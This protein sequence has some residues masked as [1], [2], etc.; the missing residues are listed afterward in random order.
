MS[1]RLHTC[2]SRGPWLAREPFGPS[3][4]EIVIENLDSQEF[5]I[6]LQDSFR[7][8]F[9]VSP[10]EP[11]EH[12]FVEREKASVE[13]RC[14]SGARDE[15]LYRAAIEYI[16]FAGAGEARENNFPGVAGAFA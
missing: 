7:F 12:F 4:H 9:R 10:D 5:W 8:D 3:S 14:A 1:H 11:L 13:Y 16:C 2:G 15:R 6:P